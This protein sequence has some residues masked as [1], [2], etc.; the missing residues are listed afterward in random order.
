MVAI[1]ATFA[2]L[3][4]EPRP[5]ELV[6]VSEQRDDGKRQITLREFHADRD[7]A[8]VATPTSKPELLLSSILGPRVNTNDKA[9]IIFCVVGEVRLYESALH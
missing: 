2:D 4:R 3:K 7:G 5:G 9:S 8:R 6:V 1:C